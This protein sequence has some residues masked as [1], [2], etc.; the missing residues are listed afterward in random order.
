MLNSPATS[1][2]KL[3][4]GFAARV[5]RLN[6]DMWLARRS[7]VAQLIGAVVREQADEEMDG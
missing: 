5:E 3:Q 4:S 1:K 7:S 6:D 2:G